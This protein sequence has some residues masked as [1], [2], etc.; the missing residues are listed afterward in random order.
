M[1]TQKHIYLLIFI[2]LAI[3][4]SG[5]NIGINDNGDNPDASAMLDV[6]SN[7][8]NRGLLIPRVALTATN[9]AG[10]IALPTT[11]LLVY[12]TA[13]A[14]ISPNNVVPGYYYN[15]GTPAAPNWVRFAAAGGGSLGDAWTILG[16][17]GTAVATNF[18]GTIDNISLVFRT[19]NS[20]QMRL[21]SSGQLT[22]GATTAGGKL[23][24]HQTASN[25]VLRLTNYG[26]TNDIRLRRT[27]GTQASPTA[28]SATS[29]ILG[30]I[31]GEG[32]NGS[33]F[34]N[35]AAMSMLTDGVGGT[36]TDMP[37]RIEFYTTPDGSGTLAE[38]MRITN[39]GFVGINMTPTM[40]LDV[41]NASTTGGDATIRGAST[42]NGAVYGVLG[43]ISSTTTNAAGVSGQSSGASG[44]VFGV[45]G[46]ISASNATTNAAGVRGYVGA[47]TGNVCG[48]FGESDATGTLSAG[49]RGLATGNN[50]KGIF[51]QNTST[52]TG[53]QYGVYGEKTGATGTGTGYGVYGAATGTA[54]T[55][56]GVYGTAS[57]GTT[58]WAGYFSGNVAL[59]GA[60]S[61]NGSV[62]TA[63]YVLTS[64]GAGAAYWAAASGGVS[65]SGA[66]TRVA[67]WDG[68]SSL[69]SNANLYW[70]NTNIR[71]GIGTAGAG[72]YKLHIK[73]IVAA[74]QA[75]AYI[76]M[77]QTGTLNTF[78]PGLRIYNSNN[79]ANA[80][81]GIS[82]LCANGYGVN[83][84]SIQGSRNLALVGD[85][86]QTYHTFD[87]DYYY[88][89][90][91]AAVNNYQAANT[92]RLSNGYSFG[93]AAN[94]LYITDG[95]STARVGINTANPGAA[96]EVNGQVKITGG[97]PGL[98]KV[99]TSDAAGLASWQNATGGTNYWTDDGTYIYPNTSTN[100]SYYVYDSHT[101][102]GSK[103]YIDGY[104]YSEANVA[105]IK[106]I[107][108]GNSATTTGHSAIFGQSDNYG[109]SN[110]GKDV[111]SR[112]V[113]GYT[114]AGSSPYTWGV[115]GYRVDN[116]G[117]PTAGVM[118]AVSDA[119]S[120]T[121]WGALGF[122]DASSNEYAGYFNGVIKITG[123]SPGAGKVL[124]SDATGGATWAAGGGGVSGS[125]TLDYIPLW[126]P[127]GTTLGNSRFMQ[128]NAN[129]TCLNNTYSSQSCAVSIYPVNTST[130]WAFDASSLYGS[131]TSGTGWQYA[132]AGG[133]GV[134]GILE[135]AG[136]YKV[137]V[138]GL[139]YTTGNENTAGVIGC[140]EAQTYFGA[141]SMYKNALW[142]AG[143]FDGEVDISSNASTRNTLNVTGAVS[144]PQAIGKFYNTTTTATDAWGTYGYSRPQD[145]W[146]IGGQFEGGWYGVKAIVNATGSNTYHANQGYVSGATGGTSY[147][148]EG[149][150]S[151][152]GTKYGGYLTASGA[153]TNYGVYAS[154]SGGTTNWAGYFSGNTA[155]TG[156]VSITGVQDGSGNLR[157]SAAN[158]YISASSYF[159]APGGAYF[160]SGAVYTEAQY[161]CRGGI[162]NDNA[163]Y[164]T[165]AGGTSGYTYFSGN[166]GLGVT[167]PSYKLQVVGNSYFDVGTYKAIVDYNA[168]EPTIHPS[169]GNWGYIGTSSLYWY[170]MYSSDYNAYNDYYYFDTYDDL[171]LLNSIQ[172][173][174]LWDPI[175]GHHVMKAN[176]KTMPLCVTNYKETGLNSDSNTF[177]S[178]TKMDGLLIGASRQLDRETRERDHRL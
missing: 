92:V 54:T 1:L 67:F 124:T 175:L 102:S 139:I 6:K 31:Y 141:L 14:G 20:E 110:V 94:Y 79:V 80:E 85:D 19:F 13:T 136:S 100:G 103:L 135:T 165:V 122:Q 158:P 81:V 86:G 46:T 128:P 88:V 26:N 174:T 43:T 105:L 125:G 5:Q 9:V 69:S 32:Y 10:P 142:Y 112:G 24:V 29:T 76:E 84:K 2:I 154:A 74:T 148:L 63:G 75:E 162:H 117:G 149:L 65:G 170:Q 104:S 12:N 109:G 40:Q 11:S 70:D 48:V 23:D 169:L 51:G 113:C 168:G 28:T 152:S 145:Y 66:A 22:I 155:T 97:T 47:S 39:A 25:D 64:N 127:N 153:G 132:N 91:S 160:N 118:G 134:M 161:Q 172:G 178:L 144:S 72:L 146:G 140:N 61:A 49:V 163:A 57:G 78:K 3:T 126:T 55:N 108:T 129:T 38:R 111:S 30:R 89:G 120:P 62:G 33:G 71:L 138:L 42:G 133:G 53:S 59:T 35:A 130:K 143:W 36:S 21:Q 106:A 171:S 121:A 147:A 123:G 45:F 17:T 7:A 159:I 77:N 16:N 93:G 41:I 151:G 15:S 52:G 87:A 116:G 176:P 90:R 44:Q 34:T 173:D 50:G 82:L 101:A 60:L 99:L 137:G 95:S 114:N 4:A 107:K 156:Y 27:Q 115:A 18:I 150:A 56:Y 119:A 164:L 177:V 68:A 96:L 157:F 167:N 58:N 166:V 73:N 37:G 83:L 131:T 98:N 8:G